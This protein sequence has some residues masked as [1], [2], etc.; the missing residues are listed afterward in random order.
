[1]GNPRILLVEDEFLIRSLISEC[2]AEE[3][4]EVV[5]ADNGTAALTILGSPDLFDALV[6]DVHMPGGPNGVQLALSA[7]KMHPDLPVIFA[8][9]RVDVVSEFGPLG[10]RDA[11][12]PKPFTPDD[13][14]RAVRRVLAP[15]T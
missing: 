2:L 7:R 6:T 13:A 11:V 4:F 15:P 9:G 5:E 8:T 10:P 12:L 1:M 3:G 14:L